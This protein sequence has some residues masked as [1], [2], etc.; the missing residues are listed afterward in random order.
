MCISNN[1]GFPYVPIFIRV[2]AS[3]SLS[4]EELEIVFTVILFI[5]Y[6]APEHCYTYALCQNIYF[7]FREFV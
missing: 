7:Y 2:L 5:L 4:I 3:L 1:I 6:I